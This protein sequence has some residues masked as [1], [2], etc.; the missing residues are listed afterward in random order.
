MDFISSDTNVWIDFNTINKLDLP[1][2]LSYTYIMHHD[3][4]NDE[5][6]NP[7][8]L[9][10]DLIRLGLRSVDITIE[11]LYL[12]QEY[13]NRH[14]HLS[15]YD[16]IALAIAKERDIPLMT[17]DA[18]LRKVAEQCGVHVVGTIGILDKLYELKLIDSD[19]YLECLKSLEL[20]NHSTIRLPDVELRKRIE[21]L[22]K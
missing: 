4:A 14:I 22:E 11:E 13:R 6:I 1:F 20:F 21:M 12:A 16:C 8:N 10:D 15:K 18:L 9:C 2:R 5:L 3:A 19:E 17:G 7:P